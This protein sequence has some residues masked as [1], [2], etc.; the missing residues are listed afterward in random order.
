MGKILRGDS[1]HPNKQFLS[2][3]AWSKTK[4]KTVRGQQIYVLVRDKNTQR[5]MKLSKW[6]AC[7]YNKCSIYPP[8]V[9]RRNNDWQIFW[10]TP[11]ISRTSQTAVSGKFCWFN[12]MSISFCGY[13][14]KLWDYETKKK[15]FYSFS[16]NCGL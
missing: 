16:K 6:M 3:N 12:R 14:W 7:D 11:W 13:S 8:T 1:T 15:L 9:Q 5:T 2:K 10:N 4:C